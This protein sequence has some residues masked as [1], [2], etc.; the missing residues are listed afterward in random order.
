MS[1]GSLGFSSSDEAYLVAAYGAI[2]LLS[3]AMA[4]GN[5]L[6]AKAAR[7]HRQREYAISYSLLPFFACAAAGAKL[8]V[9]AVNYDDPDLTPLLFALGLSE[10]AFIPALRIQF[11][12]AENWLE[13]VRIR[14]AGRPDGVS[15]ALDF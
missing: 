2:P 8:A 9:L 12:G 13:Q 10:L 3:A 7:Y 4:A 6:Y 15:M 5:M 1:P 14:V 11:R